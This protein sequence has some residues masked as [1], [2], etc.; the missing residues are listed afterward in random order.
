ML[1]QVELY[2]HHTGFKQILEKITKELNC[3]LCSVHLVDSFYC[4][5]VTSKRSTRCLAL[6]HEPVQYIGATV[7]WSLS[8]WYCCSLIDSLCCRPEWWVLQSAGDVYLRGAAG[9][10]HHAAPGPAPR[11]RAHQGTSSQ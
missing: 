9:H 10:L 1:W 3:R 7:I 6:S 4:W 8:A 2:T 11:E 5:Y